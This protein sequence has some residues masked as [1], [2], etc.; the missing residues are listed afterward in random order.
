MV[1]ERPLGEV[2]ELQRAVCDVAATKVLH[3]DGCVQGTVI[4]RLRPNTLD[5]SFYIE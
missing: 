1:I 4:Y 3:F 5:V 2:I